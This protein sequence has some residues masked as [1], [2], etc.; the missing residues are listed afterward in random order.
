MKKNALLFFAAL[1]VGYVTLT[2]YHAGA[3]NSGWDCTGAETGLSNP[4]GCKG[5]GCHASSTTANIGVTLELDSAGVATTR[6]VAGMNYTVK[7]TGT[8]NGST[9]LPKFGFQIGC[10]T[11]STAQATPTNAGTWATTG[12]P[13]STRYTG[14]SAN[15][16]VVNVVEQSAAIAATSGSGG[17]GTTYTQSFTWTAPVAGT[18]TISFWGVLNAV[19][20]N[21][22]QDSGDLW[23]TTSLVI[24][25]K[26]ASG[27]NEVN[28]L[29]LNIY[30]NPTHQ[31]LMVN[32]A[33]PV[34]TMEVFD[35]MG[36]H[37][38]VAYTANENHYA[39][40]VSELNAGI[41]FVKALDSKGAI[42]LEKFIKE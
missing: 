23:N 33:T 7:I 42:A 36:R 1:A 26:T 41:Y 22:N 9:S 21:G 24:S 17:S 4:T 10:I 40:N 13:A 12:L 38:N 27:I 39:L 34:Q 3:G 29:N 20:G 19:N 37:V 32:C 2:A 18:G 31:T 30:P 15:N 8:N 25:E 6:Y 28:A 14:A 35:M 16:F 11:G 5:S